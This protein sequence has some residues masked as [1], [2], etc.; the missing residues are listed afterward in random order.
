M[1][2]NTD[3]PERL[4]KNYPNAQF[5]MLDESGHSPFEDEPEEYFGVLKDFVED[6]PQVSA[7]RLDEWKRS[8][9]QRKQ[10]PE[11]FIQSLGWGR[12]SNQRIASKYE[13]RIEAWASSSA[14]RI[15]VS[16]SSWVTSSERRSSATR[17]A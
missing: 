15:A 13:F 9:A 17:D 14:F 12:K 5:V 6:L 8:L 1:S 4:H 16:T 10:A 2:W 3:K 11:A 7:T